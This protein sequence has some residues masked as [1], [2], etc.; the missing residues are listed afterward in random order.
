[1]FDAMS[2]AATLPQFPL[3][4]TVTLD[5]LKTFPPFEGENS[6]EES[7]WGAITGREWKSEEWRMWSVMEEV[8]MRGKEDLKEEKEERI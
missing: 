2:F 8:D 3:P 7:P 6:G 4:T 1:M 5:L